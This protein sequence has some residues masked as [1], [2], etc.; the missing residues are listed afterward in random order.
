MTREDAQRLLHELPGWDRSVDEARAALGYDPTWWTAAAVDWDGSPPKPR[1]VAWF[2]INRR[3]FQAVTRNAVAALGLSE[4]FEPY[5]R[6]CF[7][8]FRLGDRSTITERE[9]VLGVAGTRR[10]FP[11]VRSMLLVSVKS[12]PSGSTLTIAGPTAF[13]TDATL[14]EASARALRLVERTGE[15]EHPLLQLRRS[16]AGQLARQRANP[17][18]ERALELF[19]ANMPKAQIVSTLEREYDR[20]PARSTVLAWLREAERFD[21]RP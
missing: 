10:A 5:W 4:G 6:A 17:R 19:G 20:P 3:A 2:A 7:L 21:R 11:P 14:R 18:R 9:P 8:S 16:R 15:R 13:V 1:L 12:G